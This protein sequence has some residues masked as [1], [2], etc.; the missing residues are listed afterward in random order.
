MSSPEDGALSPHSRRPH[1]ARFAHSAFERFCR[2]V[3]RLRCP[4]QHFGRENLPPPPFLICA[5]HCS[6]MDTPALM[7]AGG[8]TFDNYAMIAARDYF[9]SGGSGGGGKFG[10]HRFMF[11]VPVERRA[12]R[13]S[14]RAM[15][16]GCRPHLDAGRCL[17]IYPEGTRSV[18]GNIGAMKR[19]AAAL[20]LG[21]KVPVVPAHIGGTFHCLPKGAL[22]PKGGKVS[23]RF[24]KALMP[25]DYPQ[26]RNASRQ[27]AADISAAILQLSEQGQ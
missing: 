8:G 10:Y 16:D 25:A 4:L 23:V 11:L 15:F 9:F 1:F 13:D 27:L 21:L 20:A 22:L 19:G 12:S 5:N 6:H 2:L 26:S 24:G 18:D 14:L 3:F 17:I 7:T